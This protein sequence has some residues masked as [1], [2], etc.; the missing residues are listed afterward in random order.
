M[1]DFKI[2]LFEKEYNKKFIE[3][4]NLKIHQCVDIKNSLN[5]IFT[6]NQNIENNLKLNL[7]RFDYIDNID[8]ISDVF[9]RLNIVSDNKIYINWGNFDDIDYLSY[10][11]LL[12]YFDDLWFPSS[13]DIEVFDK[14][15]NWIL[16][17]RHDGYI[18]YFINENKSVI[19]ENG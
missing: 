14:T 17:I 18:S 10:N 12:N 2:E 6:N 3:F 4:K 16:S 11:D 9:N 15:F 19:T 13:D 5:K 7:K 8:N 1:E